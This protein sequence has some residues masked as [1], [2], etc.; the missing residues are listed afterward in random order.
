MKLCE[1]G[2]MPVLLYSVSFLAIIFVTTLD[3][4][5]VFFVAASDLPIHLLCI[6]LI[7][8]FVNNSVRI[9]RAAR[10]PPIRKHAQISHLT[11]S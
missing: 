8:V 5:N 11:E 9:P 10:M 6:F 1:K 7:D 4:L 2:I 3:V